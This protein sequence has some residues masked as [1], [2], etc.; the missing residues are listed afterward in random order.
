MVPIL[1]NPC[2]ETKRDRLAPASRLE[3]LAGKK[4]ALLDISKPGGTWFLDRIELLLKTRYGVA[5]TVRETK[6]T[7]TKK[8]PTKLI[9]KLIGAG[10][11]AVVEA[12][13]D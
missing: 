6:P 11:D 5:D 4:I 3:G 12:L 2:D 8:A 13:A 1:I 7:Y 10:F 9:E